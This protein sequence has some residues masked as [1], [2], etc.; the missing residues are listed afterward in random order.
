MAELT[1]LAEEAE[2][3]RLQEAEARRLEET[4]KAFKALSVRVRQDE[5]EAARVRRERDEL[6]QRDAETH[7]QILDLL[8]KAEKERDL[9]L[10]VE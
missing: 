6:L 7:Q 4:K 5:K 9:K 2:N 1:P 8:A 10:I 3:L